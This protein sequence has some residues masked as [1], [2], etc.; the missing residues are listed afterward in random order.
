MNDTFEY[1]L[2]KAIKSILDNKDIDLGDNKK[3]IKS[4]LKRHTQ[5]MIYTNI[6]KV[7]NKLLSQ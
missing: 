6:D 7:I 4:E 5:L 3:L 2:K 1:H